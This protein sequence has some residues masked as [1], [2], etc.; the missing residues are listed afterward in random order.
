MP[1]CWYSSATANAI[2]AL[3]RD[4]TGEPG[5]RDRAAGHPRPRRR[6][7]GGSVDRARAAAARRRG[8]HGFGPLKRARRDCSPRRSKTAS[9]VAHV[10]RARSGPDE[11][12][13]A[14]LGLE[15]AGMHG[16]SW[17]NLPYEGW[18]SQPSL[19]HC[20]DDRN[21][22]SP[23]LLDRRR[24]P[25]LPRREVVAA[26]RPRARARRP[27]LRRDP[28]EHRRAARHPREP[29]AA[30]RG[31]GRAREAPVPGAPACASSTT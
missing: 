8:R 30:A 25:D 11:Q 16:S 24:R 9:T 13:R 31:G 28:A 3:S 19:A 26:R 17:K 7:R 2:S 14:V 10:A 22:L 4:V 20:T 1:R 18:K 6:A 21:D 27:P 5:D 23:R 29:A 15:D 12:G